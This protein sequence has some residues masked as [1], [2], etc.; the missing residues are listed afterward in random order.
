MSSE[1]D[2]IPILKRP[3][4]FN[5]R[6]ALDNIPILE[7]PSFFNGQRLTASNLTEVQKFH[8]ELRWLHNRS[9]HSWGIA[10]GYQVLGN[11]G[12]R[13][14]QISAGYAIDCQGRDLILTEPIE[15][16]IPAVAGDSSGKP[17]SYYL[18]VSYAIDDRIPAEI[19]TGTCGSSGAVRRPE[20]PLIRWQN[21]TE[22]DPSSKFRQ[23]EDVILS[24]IKVQ[25]C[26]LAEVAS[27]KERR[28]AVPA[29]QP[30]VSAGQTD[31][32]QTIWRLYPDKANPLGVITTVITTSAGFRV[33]PRYQAH[34]MGKRLFDGDIQ[35]DNLS[36]NQ[37]RKFVVDGYVQITSI[38]ASKFDLI[39]FLPSGAYT[40]NVGSDFVREEDIS[41][42]LD[43]LAVRIKSNYPFLDSFPGSSIEDWRKSL[44]YL[45]TTRLSVG[46]NYKTE[47]GFHNITLQQDDF[48]TALTKIAERNK[49]IRVEDLLDA[50]GFKRESFSLQLNQP[51]QIPDQALLLNPVDVVLKESFL[52]MLKDRLNWSV[53]W[54]GIEG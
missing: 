54:M 17:I 8:Q 51:L 21:P 6:S 45:R 23:G 34:V 19:Q 7:R 1:L 22:T 43:A 25:N 24:A 18:T 28:D 3:S 20:S 50:N 40:G 46:V 30:Y 12:D 31:P 33:P 52:P 26:Q 44:S 39:V 11:R 47:A 15:L 16:A 4:F 32:K 14:V 5:G 13:K 42:I 29:Q 49:R 9:L 41:T 37:R 38:T 35:M 36:A 53:S 48:N 27:S 2:N 10:F